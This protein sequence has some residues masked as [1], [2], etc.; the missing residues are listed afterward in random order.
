MYS[1]RL[2]PIISENSR[3]CPAISGTNV[4]GVV[5]WARTRKGDEGNR[6]IRP[7]INS[8]STI[9]TGGTD[10]ALGNNDQYAMLQSLTCPNTGAPWSVAGVNAT[11]FGVKIAN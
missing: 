2:V 3:G 11:E 6:T 4:L 7:S 8:G 9:V 1:P 10:L 5:G